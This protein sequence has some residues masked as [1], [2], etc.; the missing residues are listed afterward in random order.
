MCSLFVII[1]IVRNA[2]ICFDVS[3]FPGPCGRLSEPAV[4]SILSSLICVA[5]LKLPPANWPQVLNP[6]MKIGYGSLLS[7]I[8]FVIV[9]EFSTSFKFEISY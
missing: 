3:F 1:Q 8:S 6:L 5:E 4:N 2:W 7:I 9:K